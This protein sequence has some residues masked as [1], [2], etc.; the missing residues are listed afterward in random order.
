ML[1]TQFFWRS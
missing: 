1:V